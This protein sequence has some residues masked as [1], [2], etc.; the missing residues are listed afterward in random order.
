MP[1]HGPF[2][3]MASPSRPRHTPPPLRGA[4]AP[5]SSTSVSDSSPAIALSNDPAWTLVVEDD[6]HFSAWVGGML[7]REECFGPVLTADS[8]ASARSAYARTAPRLAV[9]DLHLPDGS[10]VE[11]IRELAQR[12]PDT[13]ILVL[14]AIDDAPIALAAIRAGAHGYVVKS[15]SEPAFLQTVREVLTGGSPITPS[16]ARLLLRELQQPGSSD[17]EPQLPESIAS[18]LSTR[19]AEVLQ[20]LTRGYRN[21]E[22]ARRL[23]LSAHTVN[24]HVRSIY[25][26]LSVS[27]RTQLRSVVDADGSRCH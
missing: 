14:T 2:Q 21:K 23:D 20:L 1:V 24:A 27:S 7:R 4:R 6:P 16:I 9:V 12:T 5:L 26:K 18:L 19:E 10:G 15:S 22:V 11:V 13:A 17:G 3:V 8:L 25:R